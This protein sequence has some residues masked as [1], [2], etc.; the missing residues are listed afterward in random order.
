MFFVYKAPKTDLLIFFLLSL[1]D[2][3]TQ[4]NLA[5]MRCVHA[6]TW[7]GTGPLHK[8]EL[9]AC[10]NVV[11]VMLSAPHAVSLNVSLKNVKRVVYILSSV[12]T[13]RYARVTSI[14]ETVST[15]RSSIRR[16]LSVAETVHNQQII[17]SSSKWVLCRLASVRNRCFITPSQLGMPF[18]PHVTRA[19]AMCVCNF[20]CWTMM[21]MR[22]HAAV[23]NWRF[24]R[25]HQVAPCGKVKGDDVHDKRL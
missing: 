14:S 13:I 2:V 4:K 16:G 19:Q 7:H 10:E 23:D 25:D 15:R 6:V 24:S 22:S 18:I 11:K 21:S 3:R 1:S 17:S 5:L 9:S 8:N 12:K 20:T